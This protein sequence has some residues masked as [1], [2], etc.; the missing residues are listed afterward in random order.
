M[1]E[2]DAIIDIANIRSRAVAERA[3]PGSIAIENIAGVAKLVDD[4]GGTQNIG[5]ASNPLAGVNTSL[6][7]AGGGPAWLFEN[8]WVLPAGNLTPQA[9]A[10]ACV[11]DTSGNV[12]PA[13]EEVEVPFTTVGGKPQPG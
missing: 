4:Q 12:W 8:G 13:G 10:V 5:G 11:V 3:Q 9:S 7:P 2:Q 1:A 6:I